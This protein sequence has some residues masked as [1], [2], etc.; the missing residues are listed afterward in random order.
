M[1]LICCKS[2]GFLILIFIFAHKRQY[3]V[4]NMDKEDINANMM[5][6]D[7][8]M[9]DS[10]PTMIIKKIAERV[11]QNRLEMNLTQ[12]AL[13]S[14]AGVSFA[15]LRRFE[16]TGEISI[17]SL[18]MLA[19]AMDATE[20]FSTLFSKPKYQSLDQLIASSNSYKIKKRGRRNE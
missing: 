14:R 1:Y 9:D 3:I 16:S 2:F 19:V 10:N 13:A 20:E 4:F 8:I 18:V 7:F 12:R 11:K 5:A 6:P 15:S 17:K